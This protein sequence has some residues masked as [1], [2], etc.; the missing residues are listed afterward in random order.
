MRVSRGGETL[1]IDVVLDWLAAETDGFSVKLTKKLD[2]VSSDLTEKSR[3]GA[4]LLPTRKVHR[5][6]SNLDL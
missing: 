5:Y 1:W 3:K 6:S 4:L 2:D